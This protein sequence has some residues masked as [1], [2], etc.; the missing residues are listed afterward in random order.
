[1][2]DPKFDV[3]VQVQSTANK[4]AEKKLAAEVV[5]SFLPAIRIGV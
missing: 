1:M 2:K 3:R 5:G 4:H